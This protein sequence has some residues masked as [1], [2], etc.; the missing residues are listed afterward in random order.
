MSRIDD[1]ITEMCPDGVEYKKIKNVYKRLKGTPITAEK[2]KEIDN[3]H[4]EIRVFAGGKTVINAR[5]EDIPQSNITTVPS[6]LVQSRGVIDAIYYEEPFTFKNEMWA[7]T[8]ENKTSVKFLYYVLKNNLQHFRNEASGMGSLPQISLKV[9]E[10]FLIPIPPLPIQEEIVRILDTFTTLEAELEARKMQYEYYRD[11]LLSF[12]DEVEWKTLGEVFDIRNGYTPSKSKAEFWEDGTIPWFRLEDIRTQGRIL[13]DAIQHITPQAV[14]SGKLFPAN[15]LIMS[16]TAT[17]GEHAIIT[18]D[19]L[20]NQQISCL[21]IQKRFIDSMNIKFAFY[22]C[23]ILAEWCKNNANKSGGLFIINL[24]KLRKFLI[25]IP[26]SKKQARIVE[27]LDRFD[28]LT[29]DITKGLPA[30]IATRRKQYEY[31]RDKLLA[32]KEVQV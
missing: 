12:G 7:Y 11:E 1:L 5:E 29:N 6:V 26:S 14:K 32:F 24:D 21:I 28:A 3:P 27:I 20:T 16:T 19:S 9:T 23:F 10:D 22:Y 17:I 13:T 8:A 25:P 18:V 15:S 31:Y 30:E 2:M 4:G